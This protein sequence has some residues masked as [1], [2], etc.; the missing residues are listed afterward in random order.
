MLDETS[1]TLLE[2]TATVDDEKVLDV[3]EAYLTGALLA[4]E[5]V[6][7]RVNGVLV[8]VQMILCLV[9]ALEFGGVRDVRKRIQ[10][11]RQFALVIHRFFEN[12][13]RTV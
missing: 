7:V 4:L 2:A 6:L 12:L 1:D 10:H 9:E 5:D 13:R 11:V 3:R 8:G